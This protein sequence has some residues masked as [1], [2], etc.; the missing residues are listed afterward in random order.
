MTQTRSKSNVMST[1]YQ[2][3]IIPRWTTPPPPSHQTNG[4]AQRQTL[5]R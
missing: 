2:L 5:P 1:G 3:V 4:R